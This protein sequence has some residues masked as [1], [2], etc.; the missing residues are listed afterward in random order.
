MDC[1]NVIKHLQENLGTLRKLFGWTTEELGEKVGVTKQTISNLENEK[2]KMTKT[3]YI[4]TRMVM[5]T[6]AKMRPEEEQRIL[7]QA[8]HTLVDE[9]TELSKEEREKQ[10]NQI[11]VASTAIAGGMGI[12]A[13]VAAVG[14]L[15][16]AAPIATAAFIAT[17][18]TS[19]ASTVAGSALVGG[20]TGWMVNLLSNKSKKKKKKGKDDRYEKK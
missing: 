9:D 20:A 8:I 1:V 7:L 4:A 13:A 15:I 14:L 12:A 6:E 11:K 5:E 17:S 3:Q 16:P 2:T 19:A 10:I 18:S